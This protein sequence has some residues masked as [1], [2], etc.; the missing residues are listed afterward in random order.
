MGQLFR[1]VSEIIQIFFGIILLNLS[2][3]YLFFSKNQK[4]QVLAPAL[5][6]TSLE[7][8]TPSLGLSFAIYTMGDLH[9][10][11]LPFLPK[12]LLQNPRSLLN[13]V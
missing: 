2:Y 12:V 3:R 11:A 1:L 9:P 5:V 10:L 13:T 6:V 8:L 7:V 4:I